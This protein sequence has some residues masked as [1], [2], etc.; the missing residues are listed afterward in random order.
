MY[1]VLKSLIPKAG[2]QKYVETLISE[3]MG[4]N[5]IDKLLFIYTKE[6][7]WPQYMEY[8]RRNP[9]IYNIDKAP[10]EVK[11]LF[12][13]EIVNLYTSAVNRFFQRASDHKSYRE[14]VSLLRSLIKY[15]GKKEAELIIAEQKSPTPRRPA[16]IDELSKL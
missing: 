7:M 2:W 15:G 5:D 11:K 13:E 6:K 10:K 4:C 16:L 14:G 9:S 3:A 1:A 8:I 12:H